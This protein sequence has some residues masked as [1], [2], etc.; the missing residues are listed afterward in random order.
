MIIGKPQK[1]S[2]AHNPQWIYATSSSLQE[3]SFRYINYVADLDNLYVDPEGSLIGAQTLLPRPEDGYM[4][5]NL[6]K[7]LQSPMSDMS[8]DFILRESQLFNDT[9]A[10]GFRYLDAVGEQYQQVVGWSFSFSSLGGNVELYRL[11]EGNPTPQSFPYSPG[12]IVLV[13]GLA[14]YFDYDQIDN[15]GSF[16]RF[17]V[18]NGH[19]FAINDTLFV[20]QNSPISYPLYSGISVVQAV[21]STTVTVLTPFQGN[22]ALPQTGRLVRDRVYSQPL[23]VL[24]VSGPVPIGGPPPVLYWT[25]E[26]D[27]PAVSTVLLLQNGTIRSLGPDF[28][29]EATDISGV[30]HTFNGAMDRKEWLE[31]RW[32]V[33][34]P[35]IRIPFNRFGFHFLTTVPNCWT[36]RPEND[37]LLDWWSANY[38]YRN[39]Y[40][41]VRT[42]LPGNTNPFKRYRLLN[43]DTWPNHYPMATVNAASVGPHS[44]NK[45]KEN[46]MFA[47]NFCRGTLPVLELPPMS[48]SASY[49][50]FQNTLGGTFSLQ[51]NPCRLNYSDLQVGDGMASTTLNNTLVVGHTYRVRININNA[52]G[53]IIRV[54]DTVNDTIIVNAP[55]TASGIFEVTFVAADVNFYLSAEST[56]LSLSQ[57][58]VDILDLLVTEEVCDIIDC[59]NNKYDIQIIQKFIDD[60]NRVIPFT[61]GSIGWNITTTGN[62]AYDTTDGSFVYYDFLSVP[63]GGGTGSI[64]LVADDACEQNAQHTLT[65]TVNNNNNVQIWVGNTYP[66]TL[67]VPVNTNGPST[68]TFT[69]NGVNLII[70]LIGTS[71]FGAGDNTIEISNIELKLNTEFLS[72]SEV[73]CF[74]LDCSCTGRFNNVHLLFLDRKGSF[75]PFNFTLNN[76]QKVSID[77]ESFNRFVGR[78]QPGSLNGHIYDLQDRSERT[79]RNNMVEEWTLNT[80][81]LTEVQSVYFDELITSPVVYMFYEPYETYIPVKIIDRNFERVFKNNKKMISHS[82]KLQFINNNE[83]QK[84]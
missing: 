41:R 19:P 39:Q 67:I 76:Q 9:P 42:Y 77:R 18:P 45:C 53:V 16:V 73:R 44:I 65:F 54:G 62:A 23:L 81:W 25:I 6:N 36:I 84:G 51:T 78:Y 17:N 59:A 75:I 72:S 74:D 30:L 63:G 33:F 80:N 50:P 82:V 20:E 24:N 52:N 34:D 21:T 64:T 40:L 2:P 13:D 32:Q 15:N 22:T 55:T 11:A 46:I 38:S 68:Y 26:L 71:D 47:D 43:T 48:G 79:F 1:L 70:E 31:Y 10:S 12:D 69:A 14:Q 56:N 8:S 28:F 58:G 35:R 49:S 27:I 61:L 5:I 4:E 83:I 37:V 60:N 57:W 66:L 3:Q 29:S 7:I